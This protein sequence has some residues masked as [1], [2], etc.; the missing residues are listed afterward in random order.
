MFRKII[1]SYL[2]K[3][4]NS[5]LSP[6]N[7]HLKLLSP[8]LF[9]WINLKYWFE[10]RRILWIDT[11]FSFFDNYNIAFDNMKDENFYYWYK[12]FSLLN[13]YD[14]YNIYTIL[15][16]ISLIILNKYKDE[17]YFVENMKPILYG[18]VYTIFM[19]FSRVKEYSADTDK[20]NFKFFITLLEK[21]IFHIEYNHNPKQNIKELENRV[22]YMIDIL[23]KDSDFLVFAYKLSKKLYNFY[24]DKSFSDI[25]L[26]EYLASSSLLDFPNEQEIKLLLKQNAKKIYIKRN[27]YYLDADII[28]V[29][30]LILQDVPFLSYLT[31]EDNIEYVMNYFVDSLSHIDNIDL[32]SDLESILDKIYDFST[33]WENFINSLKDYNSENIDINIE[34][35][36]WLEQIQEMMSKEMMDSVKKISSIN[37][38]FLDLY[39]YFI[40]RRL[41]NASDTYQFELLYENTINKKLKLPSDMYFMYKALDTNYFINSYFYKNRKN[42]V[43]TIH[44]YDYEKQV[45][46]NFVYKSAFKILFSDFQRKTHKEFIPKKDYLDTI[47]SY[48]WKEISQ[49]IKQDINKVYI[50]KY[51]KLWRLSFTEEQIKN[52]R[53]NVYYPDFLVF[54]EFLKASWVKIDEKIVLNVSRLKETLFAYLI[55]RNINW[56]S[57]KYEKLYLEWVWIYTEIDFDV[58]SFYNY[59]YKKYPKF[60]DTFAQVKQNK[61]FID[62][63]KYMTEKYW[64]KHLFFY[65]NLKSVSYYN[66]RLFKI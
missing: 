33:W 8:K 53:A 14:N 2:P 22:K 13:G 65:D 7:F 1:L 20:E 35:W 49:L 19:F 31:K 60:I 17:E 9:Y 38:Q 39:I 5:Q 6:I 12:N 29:L 41:N 26:Y 57:K 55:F 54:Y 46:P 47:K 23:E 51:F 18:M 30:N 3:D 28:S 21:V 16:A 61:M 44:I 32:N 59:F 43:D 36:V 4:N 63:V 52:F 64:L 34:P 66:K 27:T 50:K 25:I 24:N 58:E 48:F 15:P 10:N 62:I 40:T 11:R 56:F 45:I 42:L 37:E